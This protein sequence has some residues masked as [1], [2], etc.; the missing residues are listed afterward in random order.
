MVRAALAQLDMDRVGVLVIENVGNL[1]CP[2]GWDLGEDLKVVVVST[3]EGD[4]KPAKYPQIFAAS[5]AM[6]INKIDLL[7]YVSY[8][9]DRVRQFALRVNPNLRI[10][11]LSCTSGQGMDAWCD[12]L[13]NV[14]RGFPTLA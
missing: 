2:A 8:S 11:E 14:A 12:W 7:P 3:T 13:L 4:D 1:V 10:F 6:I 9:I 5:A